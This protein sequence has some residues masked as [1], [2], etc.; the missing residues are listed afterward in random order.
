MVRCDS[1]LSKTRLAEELTAHPEAALDKAI[2]RLSALGLILALDGRL[3]AL[4]T[5][6]QLRPYSDVSQYPG[7]YVIRETRA[8]GELRPTPA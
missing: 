3:L 1:A 5:R 8:A 2:E 4:P 7:G 6:P